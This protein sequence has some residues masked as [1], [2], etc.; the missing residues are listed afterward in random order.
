MD[1]EELGKKCINTARAM[2]KCKSSKSNMMQKLKAGSKA[3]ILLKLKQT[4][5][6]LPQFAMD[7]HKRSKCS[8]P[9]KFKSGPK[10]NILLKLKEKPGSLPLL[11]ANPCK[12]RKVSSNVRGARVNRCLLHVIAECCTPLA[13]G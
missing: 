1:C 13:R 8:A 7:K 11:A 2:D 12:R 10:A 6:A 3:N 9:Q 4:H 5:A